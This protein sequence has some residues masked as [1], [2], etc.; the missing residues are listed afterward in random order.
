ME[1]KTERMD[2]EERTELMSEDVKRIG[3]RF[4]I[5]FVEYEC[6]T[7]ISYIGFDEKME[8]KVRIIE[9][10]G[11]ERRFIE[12]SKQLINIS[13]DIKGVY[14]GID[15]ICDSGKLYYVEEA[16]DAKT[17]GVEGVKTDLAEKICASL[18]DI[19][20]ILNEKKIV[21]GNLRPEAVYLRKDNEVVLG[22]LIA[23]QPVSVIECDSTMSLENT[24][25]RSPEQCGVSSDKISVKTDIYSLCMLFL[26]LM[27]GKC[28]PSVSDRI[29]VDIDSC[30]Q[31]LKKIISDAKWDAFKKGSS[32]KPAE[33]FESMRE[34]SS[35]LFCDED[36]TVSWDGED[37]ES[38]KDPAKEEGKDK[39]KKGWIKWV[40]IA[41]AAGI[42]AGVVTPLVILN[43]RKNDYTTSA[44]SSDKETP[45]NIYDRSLSDIFVS[46]KTVNEPE[47]VNGVYGTD[48]LPIPGNDLKFLEGEEYKGTSK[49]KLTG[50]QRDYLTKLTDLTGIENLSESVEMLFLN[51]N[52]EITDLK[53][54]SSL[55]KL[56]YLNI[57]EDYNIK[58]LSPLTG[59][60]TLE[61]ISYEAARKE[62][63]DEGV[64]TDKLSILRISQ[65]L[66]ALD[67]RKNKLTDGSFLKDFDGIEVLDIANNNIKD[68]S[69]VINDMD[70]I[71]YLVLDKNEPDDYSFLTKSTLERVS[72]GGMESLKSIEQLTD[73]KENSNIKK[74]TFN[75]CKN[76]ESIS[77]IEKFVNLIAVHLKNTKVSDL[78]PFKN[79]TEMEDI[80]ISSTAVSDISPLKDLTN[81]THLYMAKLNLTDISPLSGMSKLKVLDMSENG[82]S[83]LS[84]LSGAS[85]LKRLNC[86]SSKN[87]TDITGLKGKNLERFTVSDA[88][89]TS[90]E[91]LEG[92]RDLFYLYIGNCPINDLSMIGKF[93]NLTELHLKDMKTTDYSF[94]KGLKKLEKLDLSGSGISD[95]AF[96]EELTGL[97]HLDISNTSMSKNDVYRLQGILPGCEIVSDF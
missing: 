45:E 50:A 15:Y 64:F 67:I 17:V 97:K 83:D 56:K 58:D 59:I 18:A 53:P 33:R 10:S 77:G 91:G 40:A 96:I 81:I 92:C 41:A 82:V 46:S 78:S 35:A 44:R 31:G 52:D 5:V 85:D 1:E 65:G 30:T 66:K 47:P 34:L 8:S 26:N 36:K 22:H 29:S 3:D 42:A 21:Y 4:K 39:H 9:M 60:N 2:K 37:P 79:M 23:G 70:N 28:P 86:A 19:L 12:K 48:N 24:Y 16:D 49:L 43:S 87:L 93:I 38:G 61:S 68:L 74:F 69:P 62:G 89:L 75:D 27:T 55:K 25:Y 7:Y 88:P 20:S 72:M 57:C 14:K 54:L 94:L 76:L 80:A 71:H 84:S 90:L 95:I 51:K 6:D 11:E 63:E 73:G 13:Q 32:V